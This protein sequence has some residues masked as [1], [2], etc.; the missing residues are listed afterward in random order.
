MHFLQGSL[1]LSS[2][3]PEGLDKIRQLEA[4]GQVRQEEEIATFQKP[5]FTTALQVGFEGVKLNKKKKE[6]NIDYFLSAL[7]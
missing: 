5:V 7:L 2:Q 4:K 6:W 1:D 3:R